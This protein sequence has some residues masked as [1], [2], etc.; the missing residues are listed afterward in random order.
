[1]KERESERERERERQR[2]RDRMLAFFCSNIVGVAILVKF[3]NK[4]FTCISQFISRR[5]I[6]ALGA[7]GIFRF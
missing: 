3:V 4:L 1:M 6:K 2:E 7:V 5:A